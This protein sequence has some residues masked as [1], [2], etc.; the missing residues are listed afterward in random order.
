MESDIP[1]EDIMLIS[2]MLIRP[3]GLISSASS[4]PRFNLSLG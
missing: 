3:K 1:A 2:K 4:T